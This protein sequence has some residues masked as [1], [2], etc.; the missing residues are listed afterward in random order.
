MQRAGIEGVDQGVRIEIGGRGLPAGMIARRVW[1]D[2]RPSATLRTR[3]RR[4]VPYAAIVMAVV[5]VRIVGMTRPRP[6][7][8]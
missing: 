8:Q 1:V 3:M 4:Q 2:L 7:A 6:A 5:L